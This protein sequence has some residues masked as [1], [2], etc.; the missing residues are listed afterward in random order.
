VRAL[1]LGREVPA[2][3]GRGASAGCRLA[4]MGCSS[5]Q[6]HRCQPYTL[7]IAGRGLVQAGAGASGPSLPGTCR[8]PTSAPPPSAACGASSSSGTRSLE[9]GLPRRPAEQQRLG[10]GGA[11]QGTGPAAPAPRQGSG[12]EPTE[13]P[14][15]SD[16]NP[17][18]CHQLVL[19]MQVAKQWE[20]ALLHVCLQRLSSTFCCQLHH[21]LEQLNGEQLHVAGLL[22]ER[23][24]ARPQHHLLQA[25]L[26]RGLRTHRAPSSLAAPS[27]RGGG[28]KALRCRRVAR[29]SQ[30]A[31]ERCGWQLGRLCP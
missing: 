21:V 22:V 12:P 24:R 8:P 23:R 5:G 28:H 25:Q 15:S 4:A 30:P 6:G 17:H 14:P 18:L 3:R 2:P 13:P 11:A 29:A 27:A 19:V 9:A 7:G 16:R 20:Q 10:G 31:A 1:P 26:C